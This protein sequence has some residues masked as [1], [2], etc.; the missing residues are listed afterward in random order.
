MNLSAFL[1]DLGDQELVLWLKTI[2]LGPL[3]EVWPLTPE[4]ICWTLPPAFKNAAICSSK[5]SR[6]L[7]AASFFALFVITKLSRFI[8]Q[9][10]PQ[11]YTKVKQ[12]AICAR[13]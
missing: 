9:K 4:G 6:V 13:F 10:G 1:L 11:L 12:S 3:V 8:A 2:C 5:S 7:T